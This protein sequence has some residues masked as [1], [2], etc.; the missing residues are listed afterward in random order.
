MSAY[1]L[2]I[3]NPRPSVPPFHSGTLGEG[4]RAAIEEIEGG[5]REM[6]EG[7]ERL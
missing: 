6:L 1:G 7:W 2:V 5:Y 4:M 3:V